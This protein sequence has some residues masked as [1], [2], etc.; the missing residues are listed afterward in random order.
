MSPC[1][2][3]RYC[4]QCSGDLTQTG[5]FVGAKQT[6][7]WLCSLSHPIKMLVRADFRTMET[8]S[9][10]LIL[11]LLLVIT[12]SRFIGTG[13]P[14]TSIDGTGTRRSVYLR[15]VL[16]SLLLTCFYDPC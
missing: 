4:D 9:W 13:I 12:T 1:S 11:E 7:D 14:R 5:R 6:A 15:L 8:N 3:A 2:L 10:F 16:A